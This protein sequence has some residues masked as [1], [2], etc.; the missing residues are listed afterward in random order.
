ML[1]PDQFLD[2]RFNTRKELLKVTSFRVLRWAIKHMAF[3]LDIKNTIPHVDA[4][5][6]LNFDSKRLES[7]ENSE[8]KI[9][10][11]VEIV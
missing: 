1:K 11:W 4:L 2:F 8:D 5:S 7:S 6:R 10:H 3:D 9:L